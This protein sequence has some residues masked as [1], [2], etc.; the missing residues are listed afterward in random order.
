MRINERNKTL[1]L[2]EYGLT[3]TIKQAAKSFPDEILA[4]VTEQHRELY[5]VISAAGEFSAQVSGKFQHNA[6]NVADFPAVGDWVMLTATTGQQA[7]IQQVLPRKSVLTRGAAGSEGAGQI[8]AANLDTVFICMSLNADFNIRRIERYLTIAWESGAMPVIVL[9]KADLCTDLDQKLVELGEVAIGVDIIICSAKQNEGYDELRKYTD[10]DQTVAFVGS[11]GVGKSTLINGLMQQDI[12]ATKAIR[13]DDDKG[14]HT[15]TFRQLLKLPTGGV[16]ID[17]PG[18][19]EL[20]IHTGDLAHTFQ[21]IEQ[22]AAQ[23]KFKDC[24]HQSEPGCAVRQ[25]IEAGTLPIERLESYQKLQRELTYSQLNAR[26]L[27]NEKIKRMFG[28]KHKMKQ[29]LKD[30]KK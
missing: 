17:T 28:S 12:F 23:C 5:Q 6:R 10:N 13:S 7:I 26:E 29:M 25:A 30:L 11:S 16:V 2:I 8:I 22:L 20:R 21:D 24:Q 9:T 15:T 19:R 18:M 1:N 14:R 27:E 4:R 3:E